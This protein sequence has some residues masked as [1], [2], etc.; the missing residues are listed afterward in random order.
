M[1]KILFHEGVKKD[2]KGFPTSHLEAIKT[3][4]N[5]TLLAIAA[6]IVP[7]IFGLNPA[8]L[9]INT[10]PIEVIVIIITSLV[11]IFGV[12]AGIRGYIVRHM[13]PLERILI[14]ISGLLLIYPGIVT[15]VIGLVAIA[16]LVA[17]QNKTKKIL[18]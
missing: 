1:Y 5:A 17:I 16:T 8:M 12:S 13:N 15:D 3:A 6:F 2:L 9:F 14:I 7:Y 4:I 11:G 18:I 10:N